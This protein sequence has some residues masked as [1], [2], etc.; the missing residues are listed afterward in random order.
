MERSVALQ[1]VAKRLKEENEILRKENQELQEKLVQIQQNK[2][3]V[4]PITV[5]DGDKKRWRDHSATPERSSSPPAKKSRFEPDDGF[6]SS[7]SYQAS[8]LP[9]PSSMV[10][11][12]EASGGLDPQFSGLSYEPSGSLDSTLNHF[13]AISP[14][15]KLRNEPLPAFSS[16]GCGFCSSDAICVCGDMMVQQ[17]V[18]P[19]H[20]AAPVSGNKSSTCSGSSV[21]IQGRMPGSILDNLPEYQPPVPLRRRTVTT[22][23][24]TIFPIKAPPKPPAEVPNC[25]GDPSNCSACA[26]DNFGK[27]FCSAMGTSTAACGSCNDCPRNFGC[28]MG[29]KCCKMSKPEACSSRG[30]Q[31]IDI[32][33]SASLM[34]TNEAWR[35]I[36]D[37]PNVEFSDL[38]LLADVVASRT[39]CSGPRFVFSSQP[40]RLGNGLLEPEVD[41]HVGG[42]KE[43]TGSRAADEQRSSLRLIPEEVLVECGRRNMRRVHTDGVR[44]ALRLLDAKFSH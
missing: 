38:A 14:E 44:E 10:S 43:E 18:E 21:H 16:F 41:I 29:E 15:R 2:Q 9:S 27:A 26:D 39:A 36:K 17:V 42:G 5:I 31:P 7:V 22:Q 12:P 1:A 3:S 33:D 34:P 32:E 23:V 35:K 37:H 13:T 4:E 25:S 19:P 8:H 40:E 20:L 28:D 24:N 30:F 6:Y 11:T